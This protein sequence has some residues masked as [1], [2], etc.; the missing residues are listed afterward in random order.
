MI[1]KCSHPLLHNFPDTK[2]DTNCLWCG[3]TNLELRKK[4]YLDTPYA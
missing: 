4:V 3:I 1:E 2:N